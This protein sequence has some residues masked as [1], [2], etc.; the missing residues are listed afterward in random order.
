KEKKC[1][2]NVM[3]IPNLILVENQFVFDLITEEI[4]GQ[5]QCSGA[6][7]YDKTNKKTSVVLAKTVVMSTGGCGQVFQHTTNPDIA[8]GDGIAMAHRI[9]AAIKD[10]QYIQFH[11]TALYEKDKNPYFLISE[12]VRGFRSE[13][14][15]S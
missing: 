6:F 9:G 1:L 8:T 3:K 14:H 5:K 12:A 7:V 11:P 4:N 10:M 2:Q 15:T 13:E